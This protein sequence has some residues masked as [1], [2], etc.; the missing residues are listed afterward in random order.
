VYNLFISIELYTKALYLKI[1]RKTDDAVVDSSK[2][3]IN[4]MRDGKA[5]TC[6]IRAPFWLNEIFKRMD[7]LND[8]IDFLI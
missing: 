3:I 6:Y 1:I 8:F 7:R 5:A 2:I 4:K